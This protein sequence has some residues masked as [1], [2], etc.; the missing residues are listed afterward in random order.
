M[1]L[2]GDERR[3]HFA[4]PVSEAIRKNDKRSARGEGQRWHPSRKVAV[5][6]HGITDAWMPLC[7]AP[8]PKPAR[9]FHD[10]SIFEFGA[11]TRALQ[12]ATCAI[13]DD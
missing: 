12:N 8:A 2:R 13:R 4:L 3:N 11:G 5:K 6:R 10:Y 7:F 1:T 9:H